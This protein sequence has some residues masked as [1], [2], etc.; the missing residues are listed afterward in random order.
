MPSI[1]H[2]L[3]L[4]VRRLLRA[5]AFTIAAALCVALGVG[6]NTAMFSVINAVLLK[7]LAF[8]EP[9]RLVVVHET[10]QPKLDAHGM[11]SPANFLDWRGANHSFSEMAAYWDTKAVV[12]G[13][14]GDP[15]EL[16]AQATTA[17]LFPM[18]GVQPA[19]GRAFTADEDVPGAADRVVI[20]HDV[21]Q[22]YFAGN[23]DAIG[24][25]LLI[26]GR[27]REIVGVMPAGFGIPGSKAQ[28][29][30]PF[31][32]DPTADYRKHNG[33]FMRVV[34][35]LRPGTTLDAAR[36]DMA[37]VARDLE[38]RNP[39]FNSKWGTYIIP[40]DEQV[41]GGAR[42]ALLVL[43]GV[44][45]FVLLIACANVASLQLTRA[46]ARQR[47]VAV[48]SALG[49][50]AWR[51]ARELVTESVV[52]AAVGGV[53]GVVLAVWATS[54]IVRLAPGSI[55]RASEIAVDGRT[56]GFAALLSVV[57]GLVFGA[58]PALRAARSDVY[59]A[60]REGDRNAA[61]G[62]RAAQT[63]IVATQ[64]ALSLTLLIGAGLM[65]R[66]FMRLRNVNPGFNAENVLTLRVSMGGPTY[67]DTLRQI[68]TNEE[69]ARR[70]AAMP[71]VR[72]ASAI[73]W[74]P[75]GGPG[76]VTAAWPMTKPKPAPGEEPAAEISVVAPDYFRTMQI[77]VVAGAT[78]TGRERIDGPKQ[79][80][81]NRALAKEYFGDA[82]PV[83]KHVG[84]MWGEPDMDAEIVGVVGDVKQGGLD[85]LSR[86]NIYFSLSQFPWSTMTY[87]VRAE[88]GDPMRLV[89]AVR[90]EVRAVDP[91]LPVADVR[92]MEAV[93]GETVAQR[94][95]T[96]ALLAS[97]AGLAL[98][99]A[100][101]GTYGVVSYS[102]A[103]RTRE[104]GIRIALG[105]AAHDVLAGVMRHALVVAAIGI[106]AG[107]VGALL[108]TRV[109]SGLLFEVS[110]TDPVVFVS[111]AL[112]LGMVAMVASWLPARRAARVDPMVALRAE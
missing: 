12:K 103:Q 37:V 25:S 108:L 31:R 38:A 109:L 29:W 67:R 85:S 100:A 9:G 78:L 57:T 28:L 43:G 45:A 16:P 10:L 65:M 92:P 81:V 95:L 86:P 11:V 75:F 84:V 19:V 49:A 52:L 88:G 18:L 61:H 47:E 44:V 68:A 7:P 36:R 54:A 87:V 15:E 59:G 39:S 97:F 98:V 107:L 72:A 104:F 60:L 105:G 74:L 79:I 34:A 42:R 6:A 14:D 48:Q 26:N 30:L 93:V 5:P 69:I 94:R 64:I 22:R 71:G 83:G 32:L 55:P 82:N 76:S 24:K 20:G 110:A 106:G 13:A 62:G 63:A 66:S 112:L 102:V 80:V 2:D 99:L 89:P 91:N 50:T 90:N 56:L 33:R 3:R 58:L 53:A 40:L 41:V 96:M 4:A 73:N 8:R 77:P 23:R 51:V 111:I 21:W 35:R 1:L 101:V 17:S 46:A 27:S 70:I